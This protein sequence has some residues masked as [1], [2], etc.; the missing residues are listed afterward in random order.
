VIAAPARLGPAQP[1]W[2][3]SG[4][5]QGELVLGYGRR[6]DTFV[7]AKDTPGPA[8]ITGSMRW[9]GSDGDLCCL[10]VA[11]AVAES[12]E[13]QSSCLHLICPGRRSSAARV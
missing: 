11:V 6:W 5:A 1:R 7:A 2:G 4:T 8:N 3:F 10:A 9:L 12:A 13:L